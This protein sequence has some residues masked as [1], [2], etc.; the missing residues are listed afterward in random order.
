MPSPKLRETIGVGTARSGC[1]LDAGALM[2][3]LFLFFFTLPVL[4]MIAKFT[5]VKAEEIVDKVKC[6]GKNSQVYYKVR[7]NHT[8]NLTITTS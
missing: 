8:D 1:K 4:T 3:Q 5:N 7:E 6:V 2:L